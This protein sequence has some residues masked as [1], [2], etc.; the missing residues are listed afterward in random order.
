MTTPM[1]TTEI[2]EARCRH[3]AN[4]ALVRAWFSV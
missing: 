3:V 4:R 1:E 2:K